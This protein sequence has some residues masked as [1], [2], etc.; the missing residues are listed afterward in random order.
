MLDRYLKTRYVR[1]GRGPVDT[2][3]WGLVRMA[4]AELFGKPLLPAFNGICPD[5]KRSLTEA[6]ITVREEGGFV[7][8]KATEGAIATAWRGRL[9]THVGIVVRADG[10]LWVLETDE[11]T[12][13]CLTPLS[14]FESRYNKVIYYDD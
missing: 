8:V 5:D 7:P 10:R 3:C 12:G 11:G 14:T 1:Y 2:D 4:R 9:C 6:A 13:P